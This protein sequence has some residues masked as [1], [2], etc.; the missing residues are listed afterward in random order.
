MKNIQ[1]KGL[2]YNCD[3][4]YVKG[5]HCIEHKLFQMD[6][7]SQVTVDEVVLKEPL[8]DEETE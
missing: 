8:E 6:D 4:K 3:E 7:N 2:Y 1:C 5:H